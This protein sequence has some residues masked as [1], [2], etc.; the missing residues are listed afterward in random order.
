VSL[1]SK[2]LKGLALIETLL[3]LNQPARHASRPRRQSRLLKP[4]SLPNRPL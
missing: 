4:A 2:P 1:C 3:L